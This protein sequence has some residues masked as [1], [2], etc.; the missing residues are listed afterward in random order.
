ML[1]RE[2][3]I[4]EGVEKLPSS[5]TI[6]WGTLHI[7]SIGKD[8]NAGFPVA[9]IY[10]HLCLHCPSL[11]GSRETSTAAGNVLMTEA[12]GTAVLQFSAVLSCK[13]CDGSHVKFSASEKGV[14]LVCRNH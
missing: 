6:P 10:V 11:L 4:S 7:Q 9:M 13:K 5:N 1:R 3:W 14:I 12:K 8:I 2:L